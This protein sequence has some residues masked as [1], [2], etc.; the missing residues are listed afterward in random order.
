MALCTRFQTDL[1]AE[2][3]YEREPIS[4]L[5]CSETNRVTKLQERIDQGDVALNHDSVHGYLRSVLKELE[6]PIASQILVFSKTSF[7]PRQISP[8]EPRAIYFSDDT[9]VGWTQ[10]GSVLEIS[11]IDPWQGPM[12]YALGQQETNRPT[13]ARKNHECLNC[14]GSSPTRYTP[15]HLVR[16]VF[17]APSGLP[18]LKA[19]TYRTSQNSALEERW[20]GWYVSGTHGDQRHMGNVIATETADGA[21]ID[22][23]QGAN[24]KDLRQLFDTS[25]YLTSHS[26]I[27]AL[28]I[29]EH[30][31][32]M[33]NLITR[34][35]YQTRTA[36]HR[37][38]VMDEIL[39]RPKAQLSDQTKRI[40]KSSG[41]RMLAYMLF[42]DEET[43]SAQ[44]RGTSSFAEEFMGRGP[45]DRFDRSLRDLDLR[46]R[47]FKYPCSFLIYSKAF[48]R[49]P[50]AM[51]H[52][53]YRRLWAI[54]NGDAS[55]P[56]YLH[57][58]AADRKAVLEILIETK[59]GL[60]D[61]WNTNSATD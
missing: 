7:Q 38:A 24:K 22:P 29:L 13:F 8:Q 20:G 28:M 44:I 36:L 33:H 47:M 31:T 27:V 39:G 5:T 46:R 14:H 15:G 30:Q 52:Y 59:Q 50:P 61:Y 56:A 51:K 42:C 43:L 1:Q 41:D 60:P 35:N 3:D 49:L 12:F 6:I 18:I 11:S 37:Q 23:D 53:V 25:P 54:L 21:E 26:D 55:D 10:G 45:R 48:D 9:Y 34:A 32:E 17:P 2:E 40:I 16:S 19:G 57:L 4:Y 58:S